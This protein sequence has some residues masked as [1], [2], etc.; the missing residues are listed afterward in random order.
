[1]ALARRLTY[2]SQLM[3]LDKPIGILL[4]LWPAMWALWLAGEGHPDYDLVF[5]F[6]G[7]VILMRSA[8]CVLND[9]ADRHFDGHVKRTKNRPL[10]VGVVTLKEALFLAGVLSFMAFLLVLFCNWLTIGLAFVGLMLASMYPFLK[11]VTNLPQVGLGVAFAW[12]IPMAFAAQTNDVS[13]GGWFLFLT[14]IVWT[15]IY[16][17]MYAMVDRDDD[18]HLGLKSTAIL[19]GSMDRFV[20]GLLQVLFI[21]LCVIVGLIFYLE[22]AYYVSLLAVAVLFIYQQWLIKDCDREKC[23]HAFLNNSWVGFAIFLGISLSY[24]Q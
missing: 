22:S 14:S 4:L 13:D 12:S 16:D 15:L 2:Y 3:R 5:I 24:F 6:V 9:I 1:M 7:G 11:R 19:F 10:A 23:F 18:L 8:G 21:L 20:L 17:T